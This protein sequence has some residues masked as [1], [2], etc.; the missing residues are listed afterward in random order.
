M[1][2]KAAGFFA[3]KAFPDSVLELLGSLESSAKIHVC[4]VSKSGI[5]VTVA[6]GTM[7]GHGGRVPTGGAKGAAYTYY[8]H[9]TA[10]SVAGVQELMNLALVGSCSY[11]NTPN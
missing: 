11:L 6:A 10:S 3:Y 4:S 9:Q 8:A 1:L 7:T 5:S 2:I